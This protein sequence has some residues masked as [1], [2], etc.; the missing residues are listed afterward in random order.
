MVNLE[1]RGKKGERERERKGKE[2][3]REEERERER[4]KCHQSRFP[5][6][7]IPGLGHR[8]QRKPN[9]LA[10]HPCA[11]RQVPQQA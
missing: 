11:K 2:Y 4:G 3:R 7:G 6:M 10:R 8:S 9:W 1:E 5:R